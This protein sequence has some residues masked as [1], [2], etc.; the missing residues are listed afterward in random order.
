MH[1]NCNDKPDNREKLIVILGP[2]AV[3]KTSLSLALAKLYDTSVI[4]GDAMTI[5]R[6]LDIGT[7][8]PSF[9][10]RKNI[11][12][13]LI[14]IKAPDESYSVNDFQE[15]ARKIIKD[16]NQKGRIPILAGGTGLY[17]KALLEDYDFSEQ[18]GNE[19]YR[20]YLENLANLYGKSYVH[21]MLEALDK[22]TADRLHVNDFRRVVRALEVLHFKHKSISTFKVVDE[23]DTI[24][25]NA[26]VV[27][28]RRNRN[29]LYERINKRVDD[30]I[31]MGLENEVRHLLS[32]GVPRTS[33]AMHAIGYKE[34]VSYIDG[35][36]SLDDAI[37]LIKQNTRHFAKRQITWYK[38]MPYIK[39]YDVDNLL[40]NEFIENV[41][42]DL[43]YKNFFPP[44]F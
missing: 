38:K 11:R 2:T 5:Y 24:I 19:E 30:M 8:K 43:F 27:G 1:C 40:E 32:A 25:Y 22:K 17:I 41:K 18:Q 35:E 44:N 20:D 9:S 28:I 12:H 23:N 10:D 33:Q 7:A 16:V 42:S 21:A 37:S 6:G 39:W 3:G 26:H 14:D 29:T 31:S 34:M 13:E 36:I 15:M 4:S